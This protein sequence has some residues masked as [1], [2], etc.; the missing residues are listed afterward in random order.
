MTV[1]LAGRVVAG[2]LSLST[3]VFLFVHGSWRSDNL[4]LVPDL[5]LCAGLALAAAVPERAARRWLMIALGF[6]AGV[7]ATSVASYAVRGELGLPSAVG[8][9]VALG[10][11]GALAAPAPRQERRV[12]PA[13]SS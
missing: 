3:F 4:F 8:V 5:I 13:A 9:L 12:S 7:L 1:I 11:A 10:M 6:T 2:V